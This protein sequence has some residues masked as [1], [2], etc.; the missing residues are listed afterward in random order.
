MLRPIGPVAVFGAS[1]FPLAFSVAGGDTISALA[2]G[3]PVVVKANRAHP[4]TCELVGE[5]V[6]AAVHKVGLPDGMFSML[7]GH[8]H[9][10]GNGLVTHPAI[11]AVGFTGSYTGGKALFDAATRRTVPIQVYAEMGSINPVFALPGALARRAKALAS[12]YIQ[13]VTLGVGQFC[14]NPG[15]VFG[16]AGPELD[17]FM[18]AV[19]REAEAW[20]PESMLHAGICTA[21]GEGI[22]ILD[23]VPGVRRIGTSKAAADEPSSQVPCVIYATRS[24]TFEKTRALSREVFGPTSLIVVCKDQRELLQMAEDLEGHL[25]ASIHATDEEIADLGDLLQVLERKVGRLIRNGF[26]TGVEVCPSM[27]H[28]GPYPATTDPHFTSVG[29]AAI[30]RWVRPV[31][32]QNFTD[33]MLP[34]SL[35]NANPLGLLR[36]VN[37]RYTRDAT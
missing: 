36:L 5:A 21:F 35:R 28:G 33:S 19:S 37:G 6:M 11:R 22:R 16:I 14:T 27:H 15:V 8:D 9:S 23:A 2:A 18:D 24:D 32:Y 25:T 17:R 3:C 4:G 7:H 30:L 20:A 26:P 12:A 10:I 34:P 13:S 29:T 31:C 1:N